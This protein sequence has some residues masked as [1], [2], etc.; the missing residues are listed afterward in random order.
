MCFIKTAFIPKK[1]ERFKFLMI[2]V[3]ESFLQRLLVYLI[4]NFSESLHILQ[5]QV[6]EAKL[7]MH[8][9][10][11]LLLASNIESNDLLPQGLK[12][13]HFKKVSCYMKK[14]IIMHSI[15]GLYSIYRP[16]TLHKFLTKF[17]SAG[18]DIYLFRFFYASCSAIAHQIIAGII[19]WNKKDLFCL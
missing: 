11:F 5:F 17:S 3:S 14:E 1:F 16:N 8:M 2:L 19:S 6:H 4:G 13:I 12:L 7:I 10:C 15:S 9:D 18:I